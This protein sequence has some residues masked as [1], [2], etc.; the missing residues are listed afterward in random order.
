M[1][2]KVRRAIIWLRPIAQ[3]IAAIVATISAIYKFLK[4]LGL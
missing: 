1:S 3:T 2:K 4:Y